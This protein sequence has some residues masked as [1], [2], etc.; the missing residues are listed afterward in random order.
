MSTKKQEVT[1]YVTAAKWN[2]ESK[3]DV[4]VDT[5]DLDK[6]N[7]GKHQVTV[8]LSQVTVEIEIPD[9]SEKQIQA[10]EIKQL[11]AA[12]DKEK[13]DSYVRVKAIEERIQSLMAIEHSSN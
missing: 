10:E 11:Q 6:I 8:P 9:V 1:L 13:A 12:I 5:Y 3:F 7:D 4:R 2:C